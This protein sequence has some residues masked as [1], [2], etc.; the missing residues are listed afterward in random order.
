MNRRLL[1]VCG[2]AAVAIVGLTALWGSA[3]PDSEVA[4]L[5]VAHPKEHEKAPVVLEVF[6]EAT[7]R[8]VSRD[9]YSVVESDAAGVNRVSISV[10]PSSVWRDDEWIPASPE[11]TKTADGS[12][13]A[14][15]APLQPE[16]ASTADAPGLI[17]VTAEDA[18]PVTIALEG[19]A[20]SRGTVTGSTD[21]S[22]EVTYAN[23]VDG[24]DLVVTVTTA[25]VYQ[26]V[27]VDDVPDV[28][29]RLSWVITAPNHTVERTDGGQL[30][31]LDAAGETDYVVNAPVMWDSLAAGEP[32][33]AASTPVDFDVT[34]L[35]AG[36]WRVTM[37]PDVEWMQD[38]ARVY[39]I[40]ID[41]DVGTS[42][43]VHSY[44]SDAWTLDQSATPRI[45]HTQPGSSCCNWRTIFR[46]PGYD[47]YFG[48]RLTGVAVLTTWTYGEDDPRGASFWTAS[49]FAFDGNLTNYANFTI[50]SSGYAQPDALFALFAGVMYNH[51]P[52]TDFMLVGDE[53]SG[54]YSRKDLSVVLRFTYNAQPTVGA[55]TGL[56]PISTASTTA[57][58]TADN[59]VMQATGQN[60]TPGTTQLF[61]YAFTSTD[62]G[63]AWTSDWTISGPYRVP[64]TVLTPGKNYTY[65]ITTTDTGY[66]PPTVSRTDPT[67]RFHVQDK[68]SV[69]AD[70]VTVDGQPIATAS[71]TA[72][73][74]KPTLAATVSDP[75][76]GSVW[77][78]FTVKTLSGVVV[79]DSI[80][81]S[82]QTVTA[83]G[84]YV[85]TV[86]L[87]YAI[88]AGTQYK[89]EVQAF[90]GSLA[91]EAQRPDGDFTAPSSPVREIPGTSDTSTAATP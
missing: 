66:A 14:A 21:V 57:Q 88:A 77:A 38:P 39:P 5:G 73:S 44:K 71:V 19:G 86:Q 51:D 60:F 11:L 35:D 78:M 91:S 79:M 40:F 59:V 80:P 28:A 68:P 27:V 30:L 53:S 48:N 7:A 45:G 55:P 4:L 22:S 64:D 23:A 31:V 2:G 52:Y 12:L 84:T 62:G 9:E 63:A 56:T 85:S 54:I 67:W 15:N 3:Q 16:L 58:V 8:E 17:K 42:G 87:P 20:A 29:P 74:A 13:I 69:V 18:P 32:G 49:K 65:T 37:K 72:G 10:L 89:V 76:G 33:D 46:F 50:S 81:G 83:G 75:D 1:V 6:D 82:K 47:A 36:K 90:D 24:N 61:K 26:A 34:E 25:A 70:S 41:P 43:T